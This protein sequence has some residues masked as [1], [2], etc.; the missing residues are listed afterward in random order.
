MANPSRAEAL[1]NEFSTESPNPW[2][3]I[4]HCIGLYSS[5]VSNDTA[6]ILILYIPDSV[7]VRIAYIYQQCEI[8]RFGFAHHTR[9]YPVCNFTECKV[10]K[11]TYILPIVDRNRN[12]L[13]IKRSIFMQG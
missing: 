3:A 7:L 6:K 12:M 11:C 10:Y 2:Q 5:V 13:S 8:F 4:I 9:V 1:K